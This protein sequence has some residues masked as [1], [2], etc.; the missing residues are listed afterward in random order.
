MREKEKG[1]SNDDNCRSK[2]GEDD[3]RSAVDGGEHDGY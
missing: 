3:E 2:K 1:D